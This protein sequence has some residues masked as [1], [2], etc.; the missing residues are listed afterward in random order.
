MN[1]ADIADLPVV[2]AIFLSATIMIFIMVTGAIAI[3][4]FCT[5]FDRK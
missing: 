2:V 3:N 4:I 1:R 5:I